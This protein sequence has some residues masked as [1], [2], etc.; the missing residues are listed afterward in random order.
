[1]SRPVLEPKLRGQLQALL[2]GRVRFDEP[3]SL[4]T[5]FH[6]GGP[7]QIWAE[8]P[9]PPTLLELIQWARHSDLP[10]TPVG[11]GAN[12]LVDDGGI[13]GVVV[14]LAGPGFQGV[15]RTETGLRVGAGVSLEML[16]HR[17]SE[18][19][20]SGI[21]FLA[22]VPGRLGGAIR[23]NAGTHDEE[24]KIHSV[25]DVA[26]GITAINP[27]GQIQTLPASQVGFGYRA[28]RLSGQ[29]VLSANLKLTPD[30]PLAVKERVKR[31]WAFKRRTQ[32]WTAPSAG[33]I[34]KNPPHGAPPAGWM[35]DRAGLK[36]H[37]MGGAM[38]SPIH[39]NF[40]MNC[41]NARSSDVFSLIEE[42]HRRVRQM[43]QVNLELEVQV[44]P[45]G[46]SRE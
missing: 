11:G 13:P 34:F 19:G 37:R 14:H 7:A 36:G 10:I 42:V 31:L 21:E 30:D 12:L 1:M 4:H 15:E 26:E 39:A 8:P 24:G 43:F 38:V 3:M 44:L 27:Q 32:D 35:I 45:D 22:G 18:E 33:C 5:S 29:M 28:S 25:S 20:L 2:K 16:I 46:T 40:M 9:D 6:I 17:G 41:G 23:M